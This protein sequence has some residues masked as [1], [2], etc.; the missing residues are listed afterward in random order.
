MLFSM[1]ILLIA[2]AIAETPACRGIDM[3]V[4]KFT[5]AVQQ[6]A[7]VMVL[8]HKAYIPWFFHIDQ[9][10][11]VVTIRLAASGVRD[12]IL[13]A[14]YTMPV[15]MKDESVVVL[16]APAETRPIAA[17][18][19]D[20]VFTNWMVEIPMDRQTV[21]SLTAQPIIALRAEKPDGAVTF[22]ITAGWAKQ[23]NKILSCFGSYV[24]DS[25]SATMPAVAPSGAEGERRLD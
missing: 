8:D 10:H 9:G 18:T 11:L 14:G 23:L 3:P 7:S 15:M 22:N 12:E 20:G 4:D 19:T 5:G 24:T 25:S 17:A 13:Q 1:L 16:M 21:A 6:Q 2:N